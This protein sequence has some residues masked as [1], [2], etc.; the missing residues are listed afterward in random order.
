M[1]YS[2]ST[3]VLVGQMRSHVARVLDGHTRT[4]VAAWVR[5]WD[6]VAPELEAALNE[7][8]LAAVDDRIRRN[9]VIKSQ[10]LLNALDVIQQRLAGLVDASATAIIDELRDAVDYAG[11]MQQSIIRSQL[12]ASAVADVA[13]WSRISP[14]AI[15]AIVARAGDQITK[16][17][18]PLSDEAATVMRRQL[19]RGVAVGS[20]PRAVAA[21][22][23][24]QTE[25]VF[26]GGLGRALTIAR[27]EM[28]DAHRAA[29]ALEDSANAHLLSAW[30]WTATLSNRTCPAC[31]G[32]HGQEFPL[33]QPGPEGHQNCRCTRVAKTKSWAELGFDVEEPPSLLP[34]ADALFADLPAA[35]Q[36]AILGPGRY[37]A[38]QA[39]EFPRS[40]WAR[41]RHTD[42]WR[43]S[44][45]PASA[46]TAA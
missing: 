19:V 29:S 33:E 35:E 31:W 27:T 36:K 5:A 7:L 28:L 32:M 24:K 34:D 6:D 2:Y 16:L 38:W 15:D 30:V 3:D 9:D 40:E 39:G 1:A 12:P 42:G 44:W 43:D 14:T 21:R 13:A 20:N 4:Q 8:A 17:S 46:S 41:L 22:M 18:Y 37:D 23:V 11:S 10:R 26:N 45:V 25:G